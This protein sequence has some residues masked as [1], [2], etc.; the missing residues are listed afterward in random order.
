MQI[1]VLEKK[2]NNLKIEVKGE[3]HTLTQLI[4]KEASKKA[5]VAAI[6]E[7]PF[8]E[9]PKIIVRGTNPT[10]VLEKAA[11]S[12]KLQ[13]EELKKEFRRVLK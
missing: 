7:H 1:N 11:N 4:A 12:I 10:K 8:M 5:D 3:T 13:C 6:Q 9:E 2:K